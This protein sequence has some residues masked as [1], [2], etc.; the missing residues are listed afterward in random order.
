MHDKNV[1]CFPG[2]VNRIYAPSIYGQA[3]LRNS[4]VLTL[5]KRSHLSR[6]FEITAAPKP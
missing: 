2:L 6:F 4:N 1:N 5:V 3:A